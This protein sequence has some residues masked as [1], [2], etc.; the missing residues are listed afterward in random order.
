MIDTG[1]DYGT[2]CKELEEQD[3][4]SRLDKWFDAAFDELN[5]AYSDANKETGSLPTNSEPNDK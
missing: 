2:A 3:N 1:I 5:E 4:R